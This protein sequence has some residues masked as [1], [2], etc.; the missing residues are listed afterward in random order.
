ML[1]PADKPKARQLVRKVVTEVQVWPGVTIVIGRS[2]SASTVKYTFSVNACCS[3]NLSHG[4]TSDPKSS[5]ALLFRKT[6][7]ASEVRYI[8]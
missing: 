3:S 2:A 7:T 8:L 6:Y 4:H 1:I 5:V